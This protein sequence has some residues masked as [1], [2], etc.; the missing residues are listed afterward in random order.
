MEYAAPNYWSVRFGARVHLMMRRFFIGVALSLSASLVVAQTG[1]ASSVPGNSSTPAAQSKLAAF[2]VVSIKPAS[3][4]ESEHWHYGFGVAGYSA[5]GVPLAWVI[6]QAYFTFNMGGKDA[7]SGAPDWVGKDRWDIEAK[8][9]P[10]DMAEY[11]QERTKTGYENSITQQML[12]SMLADRCKLVVHR[13][14]AEMPAFAIVIDKKGQKFTEAAQDEAKPSGGIPTPGG[15]FLVP[16]NRGETPRMKY[17]AVSMDT[18]AQ[19]LR[20]MAGGPV[21]DRT[22]LTGKYDF[23]LTWLSSL[24][25]DEREGYI[26]TDDPFPLS[27][28][29]FGALGLRVEKIQIPTEHIVIDHI[30]KPSPN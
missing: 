27:H 25:P 2:D 8:V 15:G 4:D 17:Y 19:E 16:Y 11:Q 24:D 7:V 26:S 6:H 29:N 22:G 28:W 5:S 9:A 18:F 12:Q 23:S 3:P 20:G 21:I 10:E 30:E 1:T 13:V 14:P